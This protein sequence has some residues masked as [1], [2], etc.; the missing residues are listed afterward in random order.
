MTSGDSLDTL[1]RITPVSVTKA[2]DVLIL[3]TSSPR[4]LTRPPHGRLPVDLAFISTG[5]V[6]SVLV[7]PFTVEN[8]E[9]AVVQFPGGY[10]AEVHTLR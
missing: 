4:S 9:S 7:A 10:I 5:S 8:R 6:V 2:D 3:V 1:M